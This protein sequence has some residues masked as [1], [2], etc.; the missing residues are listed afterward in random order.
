MER[1]RRRQIIASFGPALEHRPALGGRETKLPYPKAV[2]RLAL[3]QEILE[4]DL[5]DGTRNAL[6]GAV[7][8]LETYVPDSEAERFERLQEAYEALK[9]LEPRM[10][11]GDPSAASKVTSLLAAAPDFPDMT[12]TEKNKADRL[13]LMQELRQVREE[14]TSAGGTVPAQNQSESPLM[15]HVLLE[16]QKASV[17]HPSIDGWTQLKALGA[18]AFGAVL[19]ASISGQRGDKFWGVAFIAFIALGTAFFMGWIFREVERDQR[20]EAIRRTSLSPEE[21]LLLAV[22]ERDRTRVKQLLDLGV[23]PDSRGKDGLTAL[24]LATRDD[25][26]HYKPMDPA[27][28]GLVLERLSPAGI[29]AQDDRGWTALMYAAEG[30]KDLVIGHLLAKGADASLKTYKGQTAAQ[31]TRWDTTRRLIED[32]EGLDRWPRT[33]L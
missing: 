5:D 9:A 8:L 3:L 28:V 6:E 2:I 12:A 14:A 30:M 1:S 10:E 20:D 23:R 17:S 33:P 18:C 11:S 22:R 27:I 15:R 29:N 26:E 32:R 21:Q 13:R 7:I 24:M 4:E 25:P 31:I 16:R 19:V